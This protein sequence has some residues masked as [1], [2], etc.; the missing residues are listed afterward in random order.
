MPKKQDTIEPIDASFDEVVGAVAPVATPKHNRNSDL[1]MKSAR[2]VAT[3]DQPMLPLDLEVEI[4]RSVG[5]IEMGVLQNGM[6]YLTQR[7]LAQMTGAD[8]KALY[9]ITQEWEE[10][11][12]DVIPSRGRMAFFKDYLLK[13]GYDEP[14]LFIEISKNR[15]P[16]YAYPDIVCM[17]FVEYFAFEAQRTNETAINNYRNLA[18]FGLEQFIYKA[19]NYKPADP[20][21]LHNARVSLLHD[22]VPT[23]YFSV[24]KESAGFIVD[25][26]NSGLTVNE[27]TIPDASVGTTWGPYWT[28]NNLAVQ[29]GERI[30]FDH[31][32]PAEFPQS[33]SNPQQAWAY[34]EAALPTFRKWFREVYLPTKYPNY[35][36]RKAKVLPGGKEE[37]GRLAALYGP[38]Q[39][40]G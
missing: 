12:N 40:Q 8:R 19:L 37:A 21:A 13:N 26:I 5:G 31:Y 38:K 6:P 35:I 33:R 39:I 25:L 17:A 3:Q 9:D 29:F 7:G 4:E 32:Y 30:P 18:R 14:R 24:F 10:T 34:P 36:L 16:H 15:S 23:G 27:H 1:S 20:W 2:S 28:E 22:S 11:P